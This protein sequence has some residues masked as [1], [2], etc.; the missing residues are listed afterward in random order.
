MTIPL[1][2]THIQEEAPQAKTFWLEPPYSIQYRAGQYL[3]LLHPRHPG[4]RRSYSLSSAPEVDS[5]LTITLRRVANGLFSRWLIDEAAVGDEVLTLGAGGLFTLPTH[6]EVAYE[7]L[8]LFAAGSGI[9]PVFSL[10][11]SVLHTQPEVRVLLIYSNRTPEDAIFGR[12][13]RK[14][15]ARYPGRLHVEFLFSNYPDL[16]RARL[17]KD[18]LV[19]LVQQHATTTPARMLAYVCGPLD[20]MRMCTYGL[21]ALGLSADRIRRE[22]FVPPPST[23]PALPPDTATRTVE[24]EV[25]GHTHRL[26]VAFPDTILRAARKQGLTLPYSCEAGVC[27]NCVA[28]CVS[29]HVWLSY[30]EVLTERD[31]AQGL[32]LTCVGHPVG[33]NV[34]LLV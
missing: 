15:A 19:T 32:T 23:R 26:P 29:G 3:T 12:E 2:I 21:H 16:A 33:G 9:T 6:S 1:R 22:N 25:G 17:Y 31:L 34:R 11:K 20:Y 27:G 10:L 14:M 18:L 8:L 5:G 24:V 30:N 13:L 7:Q 4:L 28:R